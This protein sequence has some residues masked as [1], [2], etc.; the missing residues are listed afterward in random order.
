M[1]P[2]DDGTQPIPDDG[3]GAY[4]LELLDESDIALSR[5]MS[6]S[7]R[8]RYLTDD[9]D[10]APGAVYFDLDGADQG[11]RLQAGAVETDADGVSEVDL[12]AGTTD[13]TF[14]VL[15]TADYANAITAHVTVTAD[16]A[17]D[18]RVV[19]TYEGDRRVNGMDVYLFTD[20]DCEDIDLADPPPADRLQSSRSMRDP[21]TFE[22]LEA[23]TQWSVLV[24]AIGDAGTPVLSG[25]LADATIVGGEETVVEVPL[26]D[27]PL[28]F[29]GPFEVESHFM[30]ADSLPPDVRSTF[31]I[32]DEI[33]DDRN[34]PATFLLD[35]LGDQVLDD[36][37]LEFAY[38]AARMALGIDEA[39][40]DVIL[41]WMPDFCWDAL[42]AGGDLARV[43]EDAQVD[44]TLTI[45]EN[46][47]AG[48][49]DAI[50]REAQH[51]LVDLVLTLD[52]VTN[53]F[54]ID[55]D[56]GVHDTSALHVPITASGDDEMQIGAHTFHI[57]LGTLARFAMNRV[58]L[59]RFEGSPDSL[60]EFVSEAMPCDWIGEEI[61]YWVGFGDDD[62]WRGVCEV[63][64]SMMGTYVEA[65]ILDLDD[66]YD[67]LS[68][69]GTA[70]LQDETKDLAIDGLEDGVWN[71]ALVGPAGRF[72]VEGTF[73]GHASSYRQGSNR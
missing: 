71:A 11:A 32:L 60:A 5:G 25:C 33:S 23:E 65:S 53:R 36:G 64:A 59:P 52:G 21:V 10:P 12:R 9:G 24:L 2:P 73:E 42:Q 35:L 67:T 30:I 7:L 1:V 58:V 61:A 66:R 4:T 31:D 51:E 45:E 27:I 69:E 46:E 26:G 22:A 47:A 34:D 50:T 15:I 43:L 62:M 39:V 72:P 17:G 6:V 20:I 16:G 56:V 29:E 68:L 19:A 3:S 44:S 63:G 55:R 57:G 41:D 13:T 37:V 28:I 49:D 70:K 38:Q 48:P 18:L 14:D 40:N 54:S 8:V